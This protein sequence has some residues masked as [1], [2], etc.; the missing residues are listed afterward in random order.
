MLKI[1]AAVAENGVIGRG[2]ALPWRRL[3]AD[4]AWFKEKTGSDPVF[5][6]SKTY[7]SLPEKFRPLPGRE[8][9][10]L[11]RQSH[12]WIDDRITLYDNIDTIIRRSKSEDIWVIGGAEVYSLMLPYADAMHLTRVH[13]ELEGDTFFPDW[14]PSKWNLTNSIN[15]GADD[16][17]QYALTFETYWR[18][19]KYIELSNC[20]TPEQKRVMKA[21]ADAGHCPFCIEQ[22]ENYHKKP[23]LWEGLHWKV[24]ENMWP[25]PNSKAH[26]V[27]FSR[28]HAE[29]IED[30]PPGAFEEL[31]TI[32]R[33]ASHT[34]D[35]PGGGFY[36]RFG[37]PI[38][39]GGTV[40]HIHAHIAV[41]ES[42][43]SEALK[44]YLG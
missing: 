44:F 40:R 30:L 9:I 19:H 38:W 3:S 13:A 5:M 41:K 43:T 31:G 12:D 1:I 23:V 32:L 39:T 16:V 8:N 24:S 2:N 26:L 14:D 20:R 28:T 18:K 7:H 29:G 10:V 36:M 25:Y 27:L 17:N 22:F 33:W 35:I 4:M 6:G 21:I 37:E 11:T 34:F 42:P 15:H